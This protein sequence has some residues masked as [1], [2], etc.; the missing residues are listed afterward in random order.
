MAKTNKTREML[1]EAFKNTLTQEE[2]NW[3]KNW[4][5]P[6]LPK[7]AVSSRKYNGVN[8]ALLYLVSVEQGFKDPRWCTFNQ[9]KKQGWNIKKGEHGV[10]IEY[11]SVYDKK[12]KCNIDQQTMRA[13]IHK[14][15]SRAEDFIWVFKNYT[16]FNGQ[17][18]EGIP[19]YT[20]PK[21]EKWTE[22]KYTD[23][24]LSVVNGLGVDFY[25]EG[26]QAY[27][28]PSTDSIHVP[29]RTNFLDEYGFGSTVLH[30]CSHASMNQRRLAFVFEEDTGFGSK[31]YAKEELVAEISSAFLCA[32]LGCEMPQ[33]H[34]DNHKAYVQGWLEVL[35]EKPENLFESIQKAEE[36]CCYIEKVGELEKFLEEEVEVEREIV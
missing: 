36:V 20:Q 14:D 9:A 13:E 12:N 19:E 6:E 4:V 5:A 1:V 18:I 22:N 26:S 23:F 25:E 11:W 8:K 16:V 33:N 10:P 34:I 15:E 29:D 27:Y 7:N 31:G 35:E 17:Q 3:T 32:D 30:E 21:V 24:A 2:L 28:K